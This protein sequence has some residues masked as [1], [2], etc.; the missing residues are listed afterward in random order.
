MSFNAIR[1]AAD[2]LAVTG[3]AAI[4]AGGGAYVAANPV[5]GLVHATRILG[6]KNQ[7][8]ALLIISLDGASDNIV[9]SPGESLL[10]SICAS[11]TIMGGAWVAAVG[12]RFFVKYSGAVATSGSLFISSFYGAE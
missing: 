10:L 5:V 11:K 4:T 12:Q 9:L 7:T 3:F 8:D 2:P 6:F 1:F